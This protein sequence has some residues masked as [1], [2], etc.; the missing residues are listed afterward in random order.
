MDEIPAEPVGGGNLYP[1]ME[2]F[3]IDIII[4][5]GLRPAV[6]WFAPVHPHHA[7]TGQNGSPPLCG[8]FG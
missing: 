6:G 8:W 7:T 4:G 3:A 1:A 2:D 5:K